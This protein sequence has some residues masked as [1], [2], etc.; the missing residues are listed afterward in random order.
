MVSVDGDEAKP[1]QVGR[2][3]TGIVGT[4]GLGSVAL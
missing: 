4:A 3:G 2:G 1:I